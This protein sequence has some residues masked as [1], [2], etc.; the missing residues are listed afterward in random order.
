MEVKMDFLDISGN[1]NFIQMWF[2]KIEG[3]I[4]TFQLYWQDDYNF[5]LTASLIEG[6]QQQYQQIYLISPEREY[7]IYSWDKAVSDF[8]DPDM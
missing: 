1:E 6:E 7:N 2:K 8:R 4:Y 3:K 5:L